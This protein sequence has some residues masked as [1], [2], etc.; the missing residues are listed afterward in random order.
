MAGVAPVTV[1]SA[2]DIE[3]SGFSNV[4]EILQASIGNA[5]RTI[6]GNESSW[7]QGASTINLRGMGQTAPWCW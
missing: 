1:I 7:T 4:E 5:G 3:R 6:E 2:I